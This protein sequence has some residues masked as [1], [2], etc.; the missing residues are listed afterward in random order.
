MPEHVKV[1]AVS[2]VVGVFITFG[3]IFI[4]TGSYR[5]KLDDT[6]KEIVQHR[7]DIIAL[8]TTSKGLEH[9]IQDIK[10]MQQESRA[11]IKTLLIRTK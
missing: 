6:S 1:S 7:A 3:S 11:D 8:Y 5:Q 10:Q 2:A 9:D 4:A